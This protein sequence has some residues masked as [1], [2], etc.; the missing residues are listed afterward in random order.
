MVYKIRYFQ[1]NRKFNIM[2]FCKPM[3]YKKEPSVNSRPLP[4]E[5]RRIKIGEVFGG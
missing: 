5:N 2:R 4:P 1:T 3:V